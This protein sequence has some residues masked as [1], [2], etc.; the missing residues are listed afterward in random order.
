MEGIFVWINN[1]KVH[2]GDFD[3]RFDA[4]NP[5]Y[6][7]IY[8]HIA[9]NSHYGHSSLHM[10]SE[11]TSENKFELIGLNYSC[12]HVFLD[13]ICHHWELFPGRRRNGSP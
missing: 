12:Q 5:N 11:V 7:G 13:S 2:E 4:S 1:L 10:T 8:M 9:W 3:L 6:P